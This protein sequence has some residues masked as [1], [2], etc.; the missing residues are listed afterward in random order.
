MLH[1]TALSP[2]K[3]QKK[4]PV[5]L[6]ILSPQPD[7]PYPTQSSPYKRRSVIYHLCTNPCSLSPTPYRTCTSTSGIPERAWSCER[8]FRKGSGKGLLA[9]DLL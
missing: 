1:K 3:S 2:H 6:A 4:Q 5:S 7:L 8:I 9:T